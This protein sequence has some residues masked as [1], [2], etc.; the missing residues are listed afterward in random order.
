MVFFTYKYLSV[1]TKHYINLTNKYPS[2]FYSFFFSGAE[3]DFN[4]ELFLTEYGELLIVSGI[5]L[6]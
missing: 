3:K 6:L 1:E 2:S 5:V 4:L